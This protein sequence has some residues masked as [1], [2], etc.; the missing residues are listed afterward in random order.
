MKHLLYQI[1]VVLDATNNLRGYK[2]VE[3]YQ[4]LSAVSGR[5]CNTVASQGGQD[6]D[7]ALQD[8]SKD[9]TWVD[10][11]LPDTSKDTSPLPYMVLHFYTAT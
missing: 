1:M 9:R 11:A 10:F 5:Q 8:A 3:T 6:V 4:L 7:I 2:V